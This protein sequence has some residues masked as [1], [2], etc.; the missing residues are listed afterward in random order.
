MKR[1]RSTGTA[2]KAQ[3]AR[4][5][6]ITDAG[7]IPV[8]GMPYTFVTAGGEVFSNHPNSRWRGK[9]RQMLPA[10]NGRGYLR[11]RCHGKSRCVHLLVA[12]AFLGPKPE[13]MEVNHLDGNKRN[14]RP[15]NLEYT[16]R[17]GNMKHAVAAGL[18]VPKRGEA[19]HNCKLP[20]ETL[21]AI[22]SDY[23]R[24]AVRGRLPLGAAKQLAR[25]YG[26]SE[27][28]PRRIARGLARKVLT[29]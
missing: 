16:S 11:V 18:L 7:C 6:A 10:D 4:M 29:P 1:G 26:V 3:S 23:C 20:A 28:M 25:Q 8:L 2:T 14:N 12:G 13:G 21:A 5:D 15:E 9:L 27:D 17:S 24:M 22:A 19:H